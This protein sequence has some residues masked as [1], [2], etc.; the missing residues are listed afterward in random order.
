MAF[1]EDW[2]IN[3]EQLMILDPYLPVD[4]TQIDLWWVAKDK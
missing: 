2:E 1:N 4:N 3:I